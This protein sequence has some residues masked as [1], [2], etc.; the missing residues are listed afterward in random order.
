[1]NPILVWVLK[2]DGP[3]V[4]TDLL[5]ELV[6]GMLGLAGLRTYEKYKGVTK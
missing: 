2:I 4:P 1:V 5:M 6:L 3:A